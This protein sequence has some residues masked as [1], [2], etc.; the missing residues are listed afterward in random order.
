LRAG[1]SEDNGRSSIRRRLVGYTVAAACLA[2]VFYDLR[3]ERLLQSLAAMNWK[4]IVLAI[5]SDILSYFCQGGQWRFLLQPLGGI[6][7]F[8]ATQAIY[9]GLFAN[10]V[11]PMRA[12][13][14]VRTF[15]VSCWLSV[16]FLSVVPSVIVGRLFD[17][18]WLAVGIGLTAIFLPLPK[19][20]AEGAEILGFTVLGGILAFSFLLLRRKKSCA[21]NRGPKWNKWRPIHIFSSLMDTTT[22]GIRAIGLT[23]RF[24]F[25]FM[26]SALYLFFEVLAFWIVMRAYRI[27]L[28]LW[29]GA[30]ALLIV[31]LGTLIPTT[32]SNLGAYQFFVVFALS[33]LGVDKSDAAGFSAVVFVI[34]TLPLWIIGLCAIGRTGIKLRDIRE[35]MKRVMERLDRR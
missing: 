31:R 14:F 32:P 27:E 23:R 35:E 12:G 4:W 18:M 20:L 19:D 26:L 2:W 8:K 7:L 5:A 30:A 34:L 21:E 33:L 6:T 13:E 1:L 28:S 24:G 29:A 22:E 11:L 10:E 15:L 17:S 3:P 25:S 16:D 9:A